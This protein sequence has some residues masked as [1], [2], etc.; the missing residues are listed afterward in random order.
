MSNGN[1]QQRSKSIQGVEVPVKDVEAQ[2]RHGLQSSLQP[3]RTQ[4]K[5]SYLASKDQQGFGAQKVISFTLSCEN[6]EAIL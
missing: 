3:L 1:N 5:K 6:Q 4:L 2:L